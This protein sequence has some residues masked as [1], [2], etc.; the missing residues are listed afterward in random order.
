MRETQ[1]LKLER[2]TDGLIYDQ[3]GL[4]LWC[5]SPVSPSHR[6]INLELDSYWKV[7]AFV[8]SDGDQIYDFTEVFGE[9]EGQLTRDIASANIVL[10]N[11]APTFEVNDFMQN[12]NVE[13]GET[14][15]LSITAYDYPNQSW[16]QISVTPDAYD[17]DEWTDENTPA[18]Q[19]IEISGTALQI[20]EVNGSLAKVLPDA[21]FGSYQLIFTAID[22]SGSLSQPLIRELQV[23]DATD[24]VIIILDK[25]KPYPWPLGMPFNPDALAGSAFRAVDEPLDTN[26]TSEVIVSGEVDAQVMGN[27]ELS[28]CGRRIRK[29]QPGNFNCSSCR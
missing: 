8:D 24:P 2:S 28:L 7:S 17:D 11:H 6:Y 29:K 12:Q 27:Y 13:R 22:G 3:N 14:F 9:W 10:K 19:S 16:D 15:A 4:L 23:L 1:N 5:E 26:L 20:L 18:L 25:E 21:G